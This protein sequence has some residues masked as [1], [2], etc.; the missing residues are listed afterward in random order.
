MS[1]MLM[2]ARPTDPCPGIRRG[3][4]LLHAFT[5]PG[6]ASGSQSHGSDQILEDWNHE[7]PRCLD[8][9]RLTGIGRATAVAFAK[10]GAR[11]V[12]FGRREAEGKALEAAAP[13]FETKSEKYGWINAV[14]AVG[15]MTSLKFGDH[16]DYDVFAVN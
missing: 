11:V 8:H 4:K 5:R 10:D 7:Q 13:T 14:Q 1:S 15:K 9:R 3:N 16:L 6:T 12:V 2:S